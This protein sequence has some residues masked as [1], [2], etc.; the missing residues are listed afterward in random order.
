M[1]IANSLA[2]LLYLSCS[3]ILIRNFV[4]RNQHG[5]TSFPIGIMTVLALIFH[6][7]DIYLTM[8]DGWDLSL[9]STLAV[10]TWLMAL[11]ALILGSKQKS[12]HLPL[13]RIKSNPQDR[14]SE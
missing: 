2:F 11:I 12:A 6:G 5:I 8:E 7:A 4:Q 1:A 13:G 14:G 10:T 9:F 3:V